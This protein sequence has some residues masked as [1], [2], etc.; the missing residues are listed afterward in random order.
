MPNRDTE[1]K[2]KLIEFVR[3]AI[4]QDN[5]LREKNQIENKFRFVR[6]RLGSLLD[7]LEKS[8][9]ATA[10]SD[11]QNTKTAGEDEIL[12]YVYLYNAQGLQFRSWQ[13]LVNPKVFYEYSV[14]RPIYGEKNHID[15]LLRSKTNKAQHAYLTVAV[16]RENV[17]VSAEA[18]TQQDV[19]GNPQIK[20][21]EGSL[22]FD[23]VMNFT[24]QDQEY[25]VEETGEIV[26]KV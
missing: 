25:S 22:R 12:V 2:L 7:T 6:D 26:K 19:A 4:R 24:H 10:F 8:L 21:K 5:E 18:S 13:N 1:E 11:N 23:K 9:P 17:L 3:D 15:S 14:N 20:V 16:K